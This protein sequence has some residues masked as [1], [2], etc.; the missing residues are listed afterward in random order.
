MACYFLNDH[1]FIY[2]PMY[3]F[4]PMI[5]IAWDAKEIVGVCANITWDALS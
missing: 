4:L 3:L 5:F 2:L 1:C